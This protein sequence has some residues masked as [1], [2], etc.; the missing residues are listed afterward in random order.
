MLLDSG[1]SIEELFSLL[2]DE[3]KL[4]QKIEEAVNVLK[5]AQQQEIPLEGTDEYQ[6]Q[7]GDLHDQEVH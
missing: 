5:R 6:D 4:N 1:W 3:D 7:T 2:N